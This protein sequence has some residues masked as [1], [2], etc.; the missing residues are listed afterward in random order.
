MNAGTVD[1]SY[2]YYVTGGLTLKETL[3]RVKI[4]WGVPEI[5]SSSNFPTQSEV[6]SEPFQFPQPQ[7][8]VW[9]DASV[10]LATV[11]STVSFFGRRRIMDGIRTLRWF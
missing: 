4:H 9:Q 7:P 3:Q 1:G 10:V 6:V 11:F 2:G 5:S 8:V